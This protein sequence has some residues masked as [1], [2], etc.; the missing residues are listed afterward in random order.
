MGLYNSGR[1]H[2]WDMFMGVVC[3]MMSLSC[4][5][6]QRPGQRD[7]PSPRTEPLLLPRSI[8]SMCLPLRLPLTYG[9][10]VCLKVSVKI[11]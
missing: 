5:A 1:F 11:L 3:S 6:C 10:S 7:L 8:S 9:C 2:H 4:S